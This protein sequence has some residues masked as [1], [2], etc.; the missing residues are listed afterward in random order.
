MQ[1]KHYQNARTQKHLFLPTLLMVFVILGQGNVYHKI[2]ASFKR[3]MRN[4]SRTDLL[5]IC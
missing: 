3:K 2:I 4:T 5:I 1:Q